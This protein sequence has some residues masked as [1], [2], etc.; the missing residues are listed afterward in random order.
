[1]RNVLIKM[2]Y[3]GSN[4]HGWQIQSNAVTVQETFQK[5][6]QSIIGELPEIKGCSR[7]DAG[8]HAN[9]YCLN[10]HTEHNIPCMRL[11]YALNSRLPRDIAVFQAFDMPEDF[12]ARYSCKGK[13]YIY[14][15][16]NSRIR[17]P[18][19]EGR[20]LHYWYDMDIDS[21]QEACEYIKGTHDFTSFCTVD[22]SREIG[23]FHRT[24]TELDVVR[25][26]SLVTVKIQADGFLYN[27]VRIIV[28]TL[29]NVSEGK[30]KPSDMNDIINALDRT[31]AGAKVPAH[32]LYLNKVIY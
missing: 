11:I 5:A 22:K 23:D 13:E 18:F 9:M 20:A 4:Y 14:K 21:M 30:F 6:L 19:L 1:M 24:V 12:H 10:F 3:D 8:V 15:I 31:K 25:E 7:T 27:M 16:W 29:L 2:K 28:G 32:G 26:G 17:E